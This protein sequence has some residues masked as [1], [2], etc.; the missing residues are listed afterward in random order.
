MSPVIFQNSGLAAVALL[1]LLL[2]FVSVM[3][4]NIVTR[5]NAIIVKNLEVNALCLRSFSLKDKSS[6]KADKI[7]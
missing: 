1:L 6:V 4:F 5:T 2:F 3:P 7:W